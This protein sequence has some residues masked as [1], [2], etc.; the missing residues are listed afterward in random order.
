[1][2]VYARKLFI[3]LEGTTP[4]SSVRGSQCARYGIHLDKFHT[5]VVA[6]LRDVMGGEN[7]F[8]VGISVPV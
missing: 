3:Q 4:T 8:K 5:T 1:M 6:A 7:L 2:Q